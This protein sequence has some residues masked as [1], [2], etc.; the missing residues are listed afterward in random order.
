MSTL[1]LAAVLQLAGKPACI[2]PGV[3]PYLA[4]ALVQQE[5]GGD[6]LALHDDTT[7]ESIRPASAPDAEQTVTQRWA[8]GHS[9]GIGLTQLTARSAAQFR[10]KFGL[11]VSEALEPCANLRAGTRHWLLGSAQIYNSGRSDGAPR[12][13]LSV[14][15]I[16]S[17][18]SERSGSIQTRSSDVPPAVPPP[19]PK[20]APPAPQP[21]PPWDIFTRARISGPQSLLPQPQKGLL[22]NAR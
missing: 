21:P 1:A 7:N 8:Q 17:R 2:T 9:V 4:A 10:A 13:A 12:Y 6:P 3:H 18:I 5:S 11:T 15:A 14:E 19:P 20:P 16:A 22:A